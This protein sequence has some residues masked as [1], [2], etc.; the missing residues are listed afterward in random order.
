[1]FFKALVAICL[2]S[3][4]AGLATSEFTCPPKGTMWIRDT[5]N[6]S[7]NHWCIQGNYSGSFYCGPGYVAGGSMALCQVAPTEY[8]WNNC[9]DLMKINIENDPRCIHKN[10]SNP[11]PTDC[12]RFVECWEGTSMSVKWCPKGLLY[13]ATQRICM[14]PTR[15][16]CANRPNKM[17]DSAKLSKFRTECDAARG[18]GYKLIA[19]PGDCTQYVSCDSNDQSPQQCASGTVF[20]VKKQRCDFHTN[21]PECKL[22][23]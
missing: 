16:N 6:C 21:V 5:R 22:S 20:N 23:A 7:L 18:K 11:E 2:L 4:L 10:G 3:V 13:N 14:W 1:M 15:V 12:A 17:A 8:D 9:K 19:Y